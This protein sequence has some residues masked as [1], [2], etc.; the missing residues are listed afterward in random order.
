MF[1]FYIDGSQDGHFYT[2]S[3][4][5]VRDTQWKDFY[6]AISELREHLRDKY[7]I[8]IRKELH[9]TKFLSG[10]GRPSNKHLSKEKRAEIFRECLAFIAS[11]NQLGVIVFNAA[12]DVQSWAFERLLNRIN[13]TMQPD[14]A[15]NL[16]MLIC[17]EGNEWEY[18]KLVRKMGVYNPI[19]SQYGAWSDTGEQTKNIT[20]DRII[21]DPL[22]K[23]SHRSTVI[24]LADFCAYALLRRERPLASKTALGIHEAFQILEPVCFKRAN[25][26][27]ALGVIR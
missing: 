22:F 15:D 13:R 26:K 4:I 20:L 16:A 11:L 3:A 19:P 27:D 14:V 10:R 7:G 2:F 6:V 23:R 12:K 24:Q 9:A 17:D 25:P 21:E 8:Y 18:T 1:L 5:G